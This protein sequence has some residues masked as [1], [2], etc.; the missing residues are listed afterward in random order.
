MHICCKSLGDGN[1]PQRGIGP[2]DH[3]D[4]TPAAE[5]ME[6]A[7]VQGIGAVR[8][9]RTRIDQ[10]L[11]PQTCEETLQLLLRAIHIVASNASVS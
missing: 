11:Q 3:I 2:R 8:G 7:I 9:C 6:I 10:D 1:L 4:L 5:A